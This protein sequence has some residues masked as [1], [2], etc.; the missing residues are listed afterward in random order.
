MLLPLAEMRPSKIAAFEAELEHLLRAG[1]LGNEIDV[2]RV[3]FDYGVKRQHAEPVLTKL[4]RE[5]VVEL[6]FRVPD[7]KRLNAPRAIRMK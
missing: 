1:R 6:D 4:K 7:V 3:C 5:G 2:M